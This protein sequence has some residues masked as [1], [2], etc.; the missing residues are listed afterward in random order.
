MKY[1]IILESRL[2]TI[3]NVGL[4]F[5]FQGHQ[6]KFWGLGLISKI[7]DIFLIGGQGVWN[8][9]NTEEVRNCNLNK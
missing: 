9:L 7:R 8:I 6:V 3:Y 2:F 4:M 5:L 1:N